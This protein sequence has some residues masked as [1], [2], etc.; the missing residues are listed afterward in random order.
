MLPPSLNRKWHGAYYSPHYFKTVTVTVLT[1][2]LVPMSLK[3]SIILIPVVCQVE[4]ITWCCHKNWTLV[5]SGLPTSVRR[6]DGF[7]T[8]LE[9]QHQHP[10]CTCSGFYI[11]NCSGLLSS[12]TMNRTLL[13]LFKQEMIGWQCYQF[14]RMQIMCTLLQTD[15]PT[16]YQSFLLG[17]MLFLASIL[18]QLKLLVILLMVNGILMQRNGCIWQ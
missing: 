11:T 15:K 12:F 6:R 7:W 13:I 9:Y 16:S 17:P 8:S 3:S 1:T 4:V 5:G 18:L 10:S 2:V 14:D